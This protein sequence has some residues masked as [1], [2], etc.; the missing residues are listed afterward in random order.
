MEK[1]C[2]KK[3]RNSGKE[4]L[5]LKSGKL[6]PGRKI[7]PPCNES[8]RLKCSTR[9]DQ[10]ERQYYFNSFWQLGDVEKQRS[11]I[12]LQLVSQ[13]CQ[14][15]VVLFIVSLNKAY[16]FKKN[17]EQKFVCRR[18]FTSTLGISDR[19]IRT[20]LSK[21]RDGFLEEDQRGKTGH[22]TVSEE[23]KKSMR[24]HLTS[25]PAV[26]SHYTR[27]NTQKKNILKVGKQ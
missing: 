4:Y 23:I 20:A 15:L 22:S 17:D 21:N 19:Y 1:K 3:M 9:F 2:R 27:A 26:E 18:F 8:C 7:L 5:S 24:E 11:F 13:Y 10:L 25:I 12:V 14:Q 16:F 6:I